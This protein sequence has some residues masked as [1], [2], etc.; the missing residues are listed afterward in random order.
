MKITNVAVSYTGYPG[1]TSININWSDA[2]GSRYHYWCDEV[3]IA[4]NPV[5][6]KNPSR[7]IA[8]KAE[9]YFSTRELDMTS[10]ASQR[11]ATEA[12]MIAQRGGLMEK[13]KAAWQAEQA[14][15]EEENRQNRIR[16]VKKDHAE[17]MYELLDKLANS[18]ESSLKQAS[19][20]DDALDLIFGINNKIKQI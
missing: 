12:V 7:G 2:D 19:L 16:K 6:F 13:A 1:H 15:E 17:E 5:I 11:M 14:A 3:Y 10:K 18:T 20:L 8:Y 9:G 4:K